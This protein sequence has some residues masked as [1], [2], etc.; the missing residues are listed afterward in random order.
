MATSHAAE[1]SEE[2]LWLASRESI[3]YSVHPSLKEMYELVELTLLAPDKQDQ[4][5]VKACRGL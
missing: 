1:G 4:S 3:A 5:P 2:T